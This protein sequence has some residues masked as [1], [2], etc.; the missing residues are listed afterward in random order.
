[1]PTPVSLTDTSTH[2]SFGAA[3]TSMRPPS[4]VNFNAFDK[5][6]RRTCLTFRSSPLISPKRSAYRRV[7]ALADPSTL[8]GACAGFLNGLPMAVRRPHRRREPLRRLRQGAVRRSRRADPAPPGG[9]G[10]RPLRPRP[11]GP[12]RRARPLPRVAP[13]LKPQRAGSLTSC[14]EKRRRGTLTSPGREYR[15]PL[16]A[17]GC[18]L[19]Q[20]ATRRALVEFFP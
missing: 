16:R 6:F 18:S 12:A 8:R 5:R 13:P 10:V 1:M 4:G 9:A 14:C 15:H 17:A 19:A 7:F 3:T 11:L 2:P 20:L